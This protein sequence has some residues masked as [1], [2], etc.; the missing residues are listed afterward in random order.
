MQQHAN[1]SHVIICLSKDKDRFDLMIDDNRSGIAPYYDRKPTCQRLVAMQE[2]IDVLGGTIGIRRIESHCV[3]IRVAL[4]L[5]PAAPV[6][7]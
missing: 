3:V 5:K 4:S 7:P 2:C 6:L 1:V